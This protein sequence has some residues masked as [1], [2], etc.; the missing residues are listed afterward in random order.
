MLIDWQSEVYV[1][2]PRNGRFPGSRR[3]PREDALARKARTRISTV[4]I[5][6]RS[7]SYGC[8]ADGCRS[9]GD[10][11]RKYP[12]GSNTCPVAAT[13][14]AGREIMIR[15]WHW[16]VRQPKQVEPIS[17]GYVGR[18]SRR[19]GRLAFGGSAPDET[20]SPA[21]PSCVGRDCCSGPADDGCNYR[22]SQRRCA[23]CE[24]R[25]SHSTKG[26][27]SLLSDVS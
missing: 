5:G 26:N 12:V 23:A 18:R 9:S 21:E 1:R 27:N 19:E 6:V 7:C 17:P 22:I 20:V 10:W 2:Q 14:Q 11:G 25:Q 15:L 3:I 4:S 24:A 16:T 8:A 13:V